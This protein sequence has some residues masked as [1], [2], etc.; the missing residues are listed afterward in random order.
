MIGWY[1]EYESTA[2]S[3]G[4]NISGCQIVS[5]FNATR[6]TY[7]SY[8]VD[9]SPPSSDFISKKGMGIFVV[10]SEPTYWYGEG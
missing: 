8:I 3:L 2:I 4:E 10:V 5:F 9:V 1:H 6:Q 7:E